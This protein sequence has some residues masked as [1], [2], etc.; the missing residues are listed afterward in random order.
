MA[1]AGTG[2][3]SRPPGV[4]PS[5]RDVSQPTAPACRSEKNMIE[6]AAKQEAQ[7]LRRHRREKS[8]AHRSYS[9]SSDYRIYILTFWRRDLAFHVLL[10]SYIIM[11]YYVFGCIE[12]GI[13]RYQRSVV[14]RLVNKTIVVTSLLVLLHSLWFVPPTLSIASFLSDAA[15]GLGQSR[16]Q[17]IA[18][19]VILSINQA[20]MMYLFL[21][22]MNN[23]GL[24]R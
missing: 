9:L 15:E 23:T 19:F 10:A 2:T 11:Y 17:L 22:A 20:N 16:R 12:S 14:V 6:L 5:V 4:R 1:L 8:R 13:S 18:Y 21:Q 7:A 3:G 24:Y